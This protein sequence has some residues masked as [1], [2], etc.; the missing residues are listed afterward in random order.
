MADRYARATMRRR[1]GVERDHLE[2]GVFRHCD[3]RRRAGSWSGQE[4]GTDVL[5]GPQGEAA[6]CGV[7]GLPGRCYNTGRF[8]PRVRGA[9]ALSEEI[10]WNGSAWALASG[11]GKARRELA[12]CA[13]AARCRRWFTATGGG[14][15]GGAWGGRGGG[16]P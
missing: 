16:G 3:I 2:G 14:G 15:A 11:N 12:A 8:R 9:I 6:L 4:R 13:R 10:P 7:P 1:G 5:P